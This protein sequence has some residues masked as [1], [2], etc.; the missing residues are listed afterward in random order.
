[1]E[2]INES[3]EARCCASCKHFFD[4]WADR[5]GKC[6]LANDGICEA[7]GGTNCPCWKYDDGESY[8]RDYE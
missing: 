6:E 4:V 7:D 8:D 3:R 1:M 2:N 5:T